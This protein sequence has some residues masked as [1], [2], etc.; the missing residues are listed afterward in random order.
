MAVRAVALGLSVAL[1]AG[2]IAPG[3]KQF[4]GRSSDS[5]AAVHEF[6]AEATRYEVTTEDSGIRL[7]VYREGPLARLGHNHVITARVQGVLYRDPRTGEPGFRLEIPLD[8]VEVDP[9]D[10]RQEEGGD[11][12]GEIPA[13]ARQ[14]TR[15]NM[16]G[17]GLLDAGRWPVIRIESIRVSGTGPRTRVMALATLRGTSRPLEFPATVSD[18]PSGL[19]VTADFQVRQTDLG[20][21]PMSVLGGGLRVRDAVDVEVRLFARSVP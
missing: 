13:P 3:A 6:S 16:L 1:L 20:L 21:V 11:F 18:G 17:P 5:T 8:S 10:A 12:P 15:D 7:K 9:A 14:G 19:S 4:P 2:C